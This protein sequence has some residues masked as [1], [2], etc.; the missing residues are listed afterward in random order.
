MQKIS[1]SV[2]LNSKHL[3]EKFR[4]AMAK[5]ND[6]GF[7]DAEFWLELAKTFN[8]KTEIPK[9]FT[10]MQERC[11]NKKKAAE[12]ST[13]MSYLRFPPK[14]YISTPQ[15]SSYSYERNSDL[16]DLV[17]E[18]WAGVAAAKEAQAIESWWSDLSLCG[19]W[20]DTSWQ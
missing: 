9:E 11:K 10:K 15:F 12:W 8:P 7:Y 3:M 4:E 18:Y 2:G 1:P 14:P 16:D 19:F 13:N 6:S 20:D 5:E 17:S